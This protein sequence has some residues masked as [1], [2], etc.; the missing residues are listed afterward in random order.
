[1][2]PPSWERIR[3]VLA[4]RTSAQV[5]DAVSS[6]A[7]VAMILR[8]AGH[9]IE[10]LFIRRAEHPRDPWSGQM[11]FPGG[12]REHGDADLRATAVRETAEEIGTDLAQA[13]YLGALDELRAM[14]R[15]R[16]M[17]L[18]IT[19][20]VFRLRGEL[21]PVLSDEVRSVHWL[22]LSALCGSESRSTTEY[23]HQGRALQFPCLR[24]GALVIWGLTYRM[25]TSFQELLVPEAAR[26]EGTPAGGPLP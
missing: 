8:E 2:I 3:S 16:P 10:L 24:V 20:F 22:P 4:S 21:E 17:D 19:P 7:A 1:M 25:F 14:A 11:G 23:V 12:R 5:P 6:R 18:A 15:M 13:E 26:G 9:G